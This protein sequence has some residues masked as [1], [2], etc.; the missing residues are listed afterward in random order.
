[1]CPFVFVQQ[2]HRCFEN[3]LGAHFFCQDE[4]NSFAFL[5]LHNYGSF[6]SPPRDLHVIW[7]W[8]DITRKYRLCAKRFIKRELTS[9]MSIYRAGIFAVF[10]FQWCMF[11][12][13]FFLIFAI[14][15]KWKRRK[16]QPEHFTFSLDR[17][18][19]ASFC[20]SRNASPLQIIK[21]HQIQNHSPYSDKLIR[22][23]NASHF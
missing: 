9:H 6:D 18:D 14:V 23:L 19:Y 20:H 21:Y 11:F 4:I 3:I 22:N 8:N 1:V 7:H 5:S 12:F 10:Q 15:S 13:F 2:Q 16:A 17:L